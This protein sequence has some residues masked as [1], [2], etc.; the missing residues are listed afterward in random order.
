MHSWLHRMDMLC[1]CFGAASQG[2]QAET[3]LFSGTTAMG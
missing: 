3:S 1:I 2:D